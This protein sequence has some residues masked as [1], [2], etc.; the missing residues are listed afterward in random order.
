MSWTLR[1][2]VLLGFWPTAT[3]VSAA[4]TFT[5]Y[6]S[7]LCPDSNPDGSRARPYASIAQAPSATSSY[8]SAH[9]CM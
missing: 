7:N 5:V 6:V 1:P 2:I 9:S 4:E 8:S 3:L